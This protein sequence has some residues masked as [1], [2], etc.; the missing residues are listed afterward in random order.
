MMT[1]PRSVMTLS[2]LSA[3]CALSACTFDPSP[4]TQLPR[5]VENLQT[6]TIPPQSQVVDRHPP[7]IH[8]WVARA[9]WEF[10][11]NSSADAYNN[12]VAKR[13]QPDFRACQSSTSPACFSKYDHGDAETLSIATVPLAGMLQVTVE[14]EIYPD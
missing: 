12:W 7:T 8:G 13:L 2:L 6:L 9:D 11:T 10:R 4:D 14:L 3:W 1:I 5:E